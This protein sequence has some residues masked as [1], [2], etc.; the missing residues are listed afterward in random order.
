MA[1]IAAAL[2]RD[3]Y[4]TLAPSYGSPWRSMV[5]IVDHLKPRIDRFA[6]EIDGP[7]HFV[8]HS[9]GGL[10]VR[11]LI[12]SHRPEKLGRVVML[13]P[14]NRGSELA[15][16]LFRLRLDHLVLG[17]VGQQL[18][19]GRAGIDQ[20]ML[21]RVDY[22]LGIIAGDRPLDPV[23]PRFLLP[24]PN[25][26]KVSVASTRLRNMR[27]HIVLPVSHTLMVYDRRVIAQIL[28]FLETGSFNR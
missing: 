1:S 28:A 23:F 26:G 12:A 3:G 7:L 8:T 5:H 24:R 16:L 11:A 25:D 21:G 22:E 17:P 2:Q 6:R 18:R 10:V 4:S 27:D 15:D 19:T 14:P 20:D 9:L 13:A